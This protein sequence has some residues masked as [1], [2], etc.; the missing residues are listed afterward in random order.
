[1]AVYRAK[2]HC[3]TEALPILLTNLAVTGA[4]F[5]RFG[6]SAFR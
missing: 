3:V 1:M 2:E 5:T 6:S 4:C